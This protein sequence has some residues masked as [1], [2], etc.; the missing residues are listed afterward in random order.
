MIKLKLKINE[1]DYT[2]KLERYIPNLLKYVKASGDSSNPLMEA[3]CAPDDETA[4][5]LFKETLAAMNKNEKEHLATELL[6]SNE[7]TIIKSLSNLCDH[8]DIIIDIDS[9]NAKVMDE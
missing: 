4:L 7:Q 9:A 6:R 2:D 8:Y 5:I 1:V 3:A